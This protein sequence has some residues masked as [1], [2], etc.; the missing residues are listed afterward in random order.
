MTSLREKLESAFK[1]YL[2]QTITTDVYTGL[3]SFEVDY[4]AVICSYLGGEDIHP[5]ANTVRAEMMLTVISSADPETVENAA[6]VHNTLF[7]K[8]VEACESDTLAG[9]VMGA[10]NGLLVN[11]IVSTSEEQ[12]DVESDN[13]G[14]PTFSSSYTIRLIAGHN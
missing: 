12:P 4:P 11:G 6:E 3:G 7:G 1:V 14:K 2:G 8:V 13:N 9:D 10:G 5:E